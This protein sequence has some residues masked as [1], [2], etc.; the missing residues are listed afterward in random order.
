MARGRPRDVELERGWRK[1]M[2][3]W[4]RVGDTIGEF[5]RGEGVSESA[6]Y[7][8]R[9]ELSRRDRTAQRPRRPARGDTGHVFLPVTIRNPSWMQSLDIEIELP[10][11][12]VI[13]GTGEASPERLGQV[14][15]AL[16]GQ[17]C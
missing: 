7:F 13:R 2:D 11:G 14:A 4:G 16:R 8:W 1:R 5:C 15:A 9:R 6:F 17:A 12:T 3:R 10:D